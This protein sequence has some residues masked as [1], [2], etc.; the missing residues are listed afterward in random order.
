MNC[1]NRQTE[2]CKQ[3]KSGLTCLRVNTILHTHL[4]ADLQRS[5]KVTPHLT[6]TQRSFKSPDAN[7]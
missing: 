7:N 2:I 5:P 6:M 1:A 4:S 3:T